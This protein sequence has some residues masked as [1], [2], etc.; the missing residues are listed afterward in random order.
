MELATLIR[1]DEISSTELVDSCLRRIDQ[2]EPDINAFTHLAHDS[3]TEAAAQI[4]ADDLRPFAGVPI[5]IKDNRPV[6]GM[7]I[8]LGSDLLNGVVPQH[9]AFL[10]RRLR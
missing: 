10:V 5:A 7:P 6:A 1:S 3:A 8:T 9:D 2:L 4:G